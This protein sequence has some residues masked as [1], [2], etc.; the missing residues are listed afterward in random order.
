MPLLWF[1]HFSTATS[2]PP[3]LSSGSVSHST[4]TVGRS[5]FQKQAQLTPIGDSHSSFDS[6]DP[7]L[8]NDD[9]IICILQIWKLRYRKVKHLV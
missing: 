7:P 2:D 4:D 5:G 9:H 1:P 3:S 6:K 8:E